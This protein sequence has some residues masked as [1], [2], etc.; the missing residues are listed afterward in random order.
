MNKS[1]YEQTGGTY[2][3]N[4]DYILPNLELPQKKAEPIGVWGQRRRRYLKSHHRV[5]YYNYLT[6]G[7]LNTY[8]ADVNERAEDMFLRLVKDLAEKEGVTEKLKAENT[9]LWVQ[10]M[11]NIRNRT[12][13]IINAEVIFV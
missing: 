9:M 4:G 6:S 5:L 8:L 3:Q 13:E 10:R 11:N 7:T 12:M 1:L 2:E